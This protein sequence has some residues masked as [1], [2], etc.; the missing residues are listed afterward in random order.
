MRAAIDIELQRR[1]M[2]R[3]MERDRLNVQ[4]ATVV[5]DGLDIGWLIRLEMEARDREPPAFTAEYN[6]YG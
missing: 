3:I 6:P 2:T 4:Q 5:L 1:L